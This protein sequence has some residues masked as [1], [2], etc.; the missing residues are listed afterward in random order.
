MYFAL[1][2]YSYATHLRRGTFNAIR[3]WR[4]HSSAPVGYDPAF[5]EE[6][7]NEEFY[8]SSLGTHHPN[9]TSSHLPEFASAP[10]RNG[11]HPARQSRSSL[12]KI[13]IPV[14]GNGEVLFEGSD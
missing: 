6:D 2:L 8:M 11:R 4:L 12:A 9:G 10:A 13:T 7:D 14:Q 1:L 3:N 5:M